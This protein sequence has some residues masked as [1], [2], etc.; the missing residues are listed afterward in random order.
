MGSTAKQIFMDRSDIS[1][2]ATKI[3]ILPG[4]ANRPP[5]VSFAK[6]CAIHTTDWL[7]RCRFINA[8]DRLHREK[9][10]LGKSLPG[11][12]ARRCFRRDMID[13]GRWGNQPYG[14]QGGR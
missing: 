3:T 4:M 8:A 14:D 6:F 11:S 2:R 7:E 12:S 13:A 10:L 9:E 5:S 1:L